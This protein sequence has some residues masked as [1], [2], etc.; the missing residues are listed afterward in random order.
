MIKKIINELTEQYNEKF[1]YEIFSDR[2]EIFS[3]NHLYI[4]DCRSQ[5]LRK[6][7]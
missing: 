3:E 5:T 6:N 2:I 4:Y 1:D 7:F